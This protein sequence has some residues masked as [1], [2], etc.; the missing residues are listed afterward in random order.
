MTYFKYV[1]VLKFVC[2]FPKSVHFII[3]KVGFLSNKQPGESKNLTKFYNCFVLCAHIL[4]SV[5][6]EH[7]FSFHKN[8]IVAN[9]IVFNTQ[10]FWS[11]VWYYF[12]IYR[13]SQA[14]NKNEKLYSITSK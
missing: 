5:R 11:R 9:A 12:L 6:F 14:Q 13:T 8:K 2:L 4:P 3:F 1:F 7:H 10:S